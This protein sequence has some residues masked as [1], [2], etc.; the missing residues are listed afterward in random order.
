MF[1]T[2]FGLKKSPET[3]RV[4]SV[5][6]HCEHDGIP[7]RQLKSELGKLFESRPAVK[8]AYLA[9]ISYQDG[10]ERGVALCVSGTTLQDRQALVGQ[11]GVVFARLF[12][13]RQHLD[14][15]FPTTEQE[16]ELDSVC[17]P[18]F[19]RGAAFTAGR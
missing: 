16:A 5:R 14:I 10:P 9:V 2:W 8:K 3:M 4:R 7:E 15:V 6:F 11:I 12:D 17:R 18:F 13:I 19:E 1:K